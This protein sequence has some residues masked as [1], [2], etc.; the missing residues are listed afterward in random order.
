MGS[1]LATGRAGARSNDVIRKP[2]AADE[3]LSQDLDGLLGVG[4]GPHRRRRR[5][6]ARR[7]PAPVARAEVPGRAR[8]GREE[9]AEPARRRAGRSPWRSLV[10]REGLSH[11]VVR[12]QTAMSLCGGA[13]LLWAVHLLVGMLTEPTSALLMV[14]WTSRRFRRR[15]CPNS[16]GCRCSSFP[17]VTCCASRPSEPFGPSPARSRSPTRIGVRRRRLLRPCQRAGPRSKRLSMR[18]RRRPARPPGKPRTAPTRP[19]SSA[20]TVTS[21]V[22]SMEP[23]LETARRPVTAAPAVAP[24][25]L[26]PPDGDG[27]R[28]EDRPAGAGAPVPA[29]TR[30]AAP[31][32]TQHLTDELLTRDTSEEPLRISATRVLAQLLRAARLRGRGAWSSRV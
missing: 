22:T 5:T 28:S 1:V 11:V 2:F 30:E 29:E 8:R 21:M 14:V 7:L 26:P 13:L 31:S 9:R 10:D 3:L 19:P 23:R 17:F 32:P 15:H 18:R 6:S 16:S 4:A 20:A 12:P 27:R 24:P 25:A